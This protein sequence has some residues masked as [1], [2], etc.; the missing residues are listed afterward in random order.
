MSLTFNIKIPGIV[1]LQNNNLPCTV[2]SSFVEILVTHETSYEVILNLYYGSLTQFK[3]LTDIAAYDL[4]GN[5]FRF[6]LSYL[7]LSTLYNT[8]FKL[9]TKLEEKSPKI[10]SLCEI[11]SGS[12]WL[13]REVWDFFGVFFINHPD[14]RRLLT[15]YGYSGFPL[16]KDFPLVGFFD[17]FYNDIDKKIFKNYLVLSQ[18][19]RN[20]LTIIN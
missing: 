20:N 2:V 5:K 11:Y 10:E 18:D 16:R 6:G 3:T 17:L 14:L 13:E 8:R 1:Y 19:F 15:D 9:I 4:P 7:F 12:L